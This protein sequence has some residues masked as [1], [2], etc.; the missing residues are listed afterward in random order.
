MKIWKLDF[1]LEGLNNTGKD[2]LGEHIGI[3]FIDFGDDFLSAKI[4]CG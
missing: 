2:T 1:T 4:A 3:E